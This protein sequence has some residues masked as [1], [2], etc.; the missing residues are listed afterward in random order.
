MI[1]VYIPHSGKR[2]VLLSLVGGQAQL[3]ALGAELPKVMVHVQIA[4]AHPF[5]FRQLPEDRMKLQRGD[6]RPA[7]EPFEQV[8][9][10]AHVALYPCRR[11][12][13]EPRVALR[14][15]PYSEGPWSWEPQAC[16]F[17][18]GAGKPIA[19]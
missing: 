15:C 1:R 16:R 14:N 11:S 17:E 13:A 3:T 10:L 12:A 8:P 18:E 6:P 9:K 4:P 5:L 2:P 19:Y 7:C